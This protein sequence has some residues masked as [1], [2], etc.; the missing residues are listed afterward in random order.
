M[1]EIGYRGGQFYFWRK[2]EY[3][4]KTPKLPQVTTNFIT[5]CFEYTSPR[6]NNV[7][8]DRH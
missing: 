2:P 8:S 4:E 3:T 6:T 5:S 7:S 1:G